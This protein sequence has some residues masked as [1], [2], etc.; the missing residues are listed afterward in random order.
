MNLEEIK[1]LDLMNQIL[2][3][4]ESK[5]DRT[6]VGTKSLFGTQLHFDISGSKIPLLTTKKVFVRGIIE[7]LLF[8]INGKTQTKEL[9]EKGVRIWEGNTSREFLDSRGLTHYEVGEM[10]PMYGSLW[11]NF[12]GV[13][14][15]ADVLDQIKNN[16]DS[17]RMLITAYDPSKLKDSVLAPC[18]ILYQFYVGSKGLSCHYTQ[19]SVD[20]CAGLP[21]N[22]VSA[23]VLTR[24]LAKAA[25]IGTDKLIMSGGDTH[26]YSTHFENAKE[27]AGREPYDFPTLEILKDVQSISDMEKLEFK[28]FQ[29]NNYKCCPAIK[30]EMAI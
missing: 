14:Q 26:I 24:L 19:R 30:Y 9:S 4:G 6:G 20:Y 28:D 29:I 16:P 5:K 2:Y 15:L 25:G 27:Q 1:Y 17:R 18:H 8:F 12:N 11:R 23:T 7:E 21:F 22:L 13:D 3:H 10:G